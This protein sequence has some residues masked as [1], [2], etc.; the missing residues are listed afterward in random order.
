[1]KALRQYLEL[2]KLSGVDEV[3]PTAA[4]ARMELATPQGVTPGEQ[5]D[6]LRN[7]YSDCR[8]CALHEERRFFVYGEGDPQAKLMLIGEGPGREENETGRP[9]VGPAGQ[10]LTKMLQAIQLE[11][12]QVYI[13]NIVKCRPPGNRVPLPAEAAA[14]MPYLL[15]Q[16]HIVRPRILLCLGATAAK[17]LLKL[18]LSVGRLREMAH[19]F[20]D[21][22]AFVTYHPSALLR[23]PTYKRPAWED[24]K[25]VRA[26][27]DRLS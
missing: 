6:F 21:I 11:R 26:E 17:N 16:I 5:L 25:K 24:L 4:P 18:E 10:L 23:D 8:N 12:E 7:Q 9:F 2:L 20:G 14:C 22:P 3:W 1:M 19:R 13:A 27:L 15:Q